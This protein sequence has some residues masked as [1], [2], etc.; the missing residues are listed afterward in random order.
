M[1]EGAMV[2]N[3]FTVPLG[4]GYSVLKKVSSLFNGG[5]KRCGNVRGECMKCGC[6][7]VGF[8]GH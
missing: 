5:K 1:E 3:Q 4:S 7:I 6:C 8:F 2:Q